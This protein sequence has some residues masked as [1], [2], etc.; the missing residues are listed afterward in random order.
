MKNALFIILLIAVTTLAHASN[1]LNVVATATPYTVSMK[2]DSRG[3][4][5]VSFIL[6]RNGQTRLT[7][8]RCGDPACATVT[9]VKL[10][11][12]PGRVMKI[13]MVLNQAGVPVI[14]YQNKDGDLLL[15]TCGNL[16]CSSGNVIS[17]ADSQGNTGFGVSLALDASGNPVASYSSNQNGGLRVLHC[18]DATCQSG[19]AIT[20]VDLAAAAAD[21][22]LALD[23]VGNPVIAYYQMVTGGTKNINVVHC[24]DPL[25]TSFSSAT[26]DNTVE[27]DQIGLSMVLDSGGNPVLSYDKELFHGFQ[28]RVLHCID[29]SCSSGATPTTVDQ[30]C[31]AGAGPSVAVDALGKPVVSYESEGA[32]GCE[33]LFINVLHCGDTTCTSG[34]VNAMAVS[35]D[36]FPP[37]GG[38]LVLDGTGNPVIA[39]DSLGDNEVVLLHCGTT[40]CQ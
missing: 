34:N 40:T 16:N 20:T 15:L 23:T 37:N 8:V 2:L 19:S 13:S 38:S 29:S 31:N 26:V 14:A 4:P 22:A 35:G 39:F 24:S 1:T 7:F 5:A 32:G 12:S 10:L 36:F 11:D 25:C 17:D 33:S 27:S 18:G 9:K 3:N 21:T 6:F 28:L 30:L